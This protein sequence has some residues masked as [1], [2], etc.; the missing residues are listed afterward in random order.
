MLVGE[1]VV[2]VEADQRCGGEAD[3]ETRDADQRVEL[4]ARD[5]SERQRQIV[6][7][8]VPTPVVIGCG[9]TRTE[10][11]SPA[12]RWPGASTSV[13]SRRQRGSA[14]TRGLVAPRVRA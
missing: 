9:F 12:S 7:Q 11:R 2:N 14:S 6:P 4:V 8:H 13:S 1:L 3:R 5:V 10:A